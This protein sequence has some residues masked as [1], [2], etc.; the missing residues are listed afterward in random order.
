MQQLD[1]QQLDD[2]IDAFLSRKHQQF[3]RLRLRDTKRQKN[4]EPSDERLKRFGKAD[5]KPRTYAWL[6]HI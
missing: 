5:P 6:A 1:A 3:P 2:R 4:T